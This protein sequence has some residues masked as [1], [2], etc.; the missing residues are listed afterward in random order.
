MFKKPIVLEFS[1]NNM[2]NYYNMPK[3]PTENSPKVEIFVDDKV[4][5]RPTYVTTRS[6][7]FRETAASAWWSKKA[8]A[9]ACW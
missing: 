8:P 9:V 2:S 1:G 6:S 5:K 7:R 4:S 3:L